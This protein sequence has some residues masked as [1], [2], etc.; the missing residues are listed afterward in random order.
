MLSML[1]QKRKKLATTMKLSKRSNKNSLKANGGGELSEEYLKK[2]EKN[3]AAVKRARQKA[4]ERANKTNQRIQSIRTENKELEERIKA[5][6]AELTAIKDVY[7]KYTG[8][9]SVF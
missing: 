4:K 5:L 8:R 2:R 7:A 6:S 3:N 1:I 9:S